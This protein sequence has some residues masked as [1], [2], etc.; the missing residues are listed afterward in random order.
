MIYYWFD[1]INRLV[2]RSKLNVVNSIG[3]E[4]DN[5]FGK[6]K[7]FW[8]DLVGRFP[9]PKLAPINPPTMQAFVSV[10]PDIKSV[11]VMDSL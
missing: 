6:F 5:L 9:T 1:P 10:S 2:K 8:T 11:R 7:I 3:R 4:F